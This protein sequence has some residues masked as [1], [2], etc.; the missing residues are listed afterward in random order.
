MEDVVQRGALS[1]R[2]LLVVA[3]TL[4]LASCLPWVNQSPERS[5][6]VAD[7][8]AKV[9]MPGA[10]ELAHFAREKEFTV[11]GQA[12]AFDAHVFGTSARE[13]EVIAFYDQRIT[14]LG[15]VRDD[16][17]VF[18][19]STDLKA[20]GWCKS[21]MAYRLAIKDQRRAFNPEFYRGKTYVTVY[22]AGLQAREPDAKCIAGRS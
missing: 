10:D 21:R 13:Q 2:W 1:R 15:W 8:A 3:A 22:D 7:P 20:R 14:A 6:L 9:R 16:F 4:L 11:E 12:H 5:E 17:A 18:A 19:G